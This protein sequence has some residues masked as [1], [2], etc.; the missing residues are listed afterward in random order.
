[1]LKIIRII[2]IVF[3]FI[4]YVCECIACIYVFALC[5]ALVPMAVSGSYSL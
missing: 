3:R 1:M 2:K 4:F 5:A